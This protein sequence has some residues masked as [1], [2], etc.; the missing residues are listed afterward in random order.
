MSINANANGKCTCWILAA[1]S[2]E[3]EY[4]MLVCIILFFSVLCTVNVVQTE[5]LKANVNMHWCSVCT[6]LSEMNVF[7]WSLK[8]RK[9]LQTH[10]EIGSYYFFDLNK[11]IYSNTHFHQHICTFIRENVCSCAMCTLQRDNRWMNR[12]DSNRNRFI[13]KF[14]WLLSNLFIRKILKKKSFK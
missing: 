9:F 1:T 11:N 7:V 14:I 13:G 4:S 6:Q 8:L 2:A 3:I 5:W 12:T 10:T